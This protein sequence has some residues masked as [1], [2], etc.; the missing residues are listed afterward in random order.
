[1]AH[2]VWFRS[3]NGIAAPCDIKIISIVVMAIPSVVINSFKGERWSTNATFTS[4]VID[5]IEKYFDASAM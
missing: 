4:V 2:T 1:M 3:C 5:N